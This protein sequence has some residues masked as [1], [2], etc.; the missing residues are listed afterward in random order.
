MLYQLFNTF[1][2][3]GCFTIGG[4]YAMVPVIQ[5]EI[6]ENKKWI[7]QDEFLDAIALTNSLPGPLATNAATYVGYKMAGIPGTLAAVFATA[8][9]SF[10]IILT[11]AIFFTSI[12]DNIMVQHIFSGVRPAV[13]SLIVYAVIKLAKS[14]GFKTKNVIISVGTL[15]GM[16]FLNIHPFIAVTASGIIGFFFFREEEGK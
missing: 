2:K 15:L 1:F 6:V 10:L 5:R 7:T 11:I 16:I 14:I 13:V 12:K 9:P 8:L 3:I 4:G